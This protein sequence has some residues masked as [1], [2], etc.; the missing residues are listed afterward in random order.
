MNGIRKS[1]LFLFLL[2]IM[3]CACTPAVRNPVSIQSVQWLTEGPAREY[4]INP[5]DQLELKFFYNA[6]L[7]ELVTVRPD[8]RISLQ[9]VNEIKVAGL[10]PAELREQLKEIYSKD[11]DNPEIAVIVRTFSAQRVYVDGEVTKPGL[12]PLTDLMTTMQAIS[13]AGGMKETARRD[14]VIL[15]RVGEGNRAVSTM[16]NLELAI[17]GTDMKQDMQLA[18][19]DIIYVP[20]SHIS[21]VNL[22][23]D[24]YIRR[25]L[26]ITPG[27]AIAP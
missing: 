1:A 4:R 15:I 3:V 17:D 5:G 18:S 2:P 23:V 26:P 6:E 19:N 8:G 24:Q 16:L 13:Q 27:F 14:E 20:R 25:M 22:W 11:I 7:N 10:T 12:V 21:N 9:L